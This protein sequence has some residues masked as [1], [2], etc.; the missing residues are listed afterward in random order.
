VLTEVISWLT[1]P[2]NWGG[3]GGILYQLGYHILYSLVS[4]VV[5]TAVAAPVAVCIGHT[6]RGKQT[7]MALANAARALPTLGL[8]ILLVILISPSFSSDLAF[9]V[10]GLIV[11]VLLAVPPII[12]GIVTGF[13]SVPDYVIDAARGMGMSEISI[14]FRVEIPCATALGISGIRSAL[15]QIVSTATVAAYVSLN[16]LGRFILDGR[17]MNDYA[18]IAG[19]AVLITLLALVMDLIFMAAQRVAVPRGLRVKK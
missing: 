15:L 8:L 5:A 14:V 16:G 10:P 4:L 6:G 13:D 1:D 7:V 17:A 12:T 9:L 2:G 18:Q 11:L 19:G 3:D